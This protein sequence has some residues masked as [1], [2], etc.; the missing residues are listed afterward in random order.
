VAESC[1]PWPHRR[2]RRTRESPSPDLAMFG[3]MEKARDLTNARR[4]R[5]NGCLPRGLVRAAHTRH[6]LTPPTTR[7]FASTRAAV[8]FDMRL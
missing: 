2:T 8:S 6:F 7:I 4:L 1:D 3:V 5:N